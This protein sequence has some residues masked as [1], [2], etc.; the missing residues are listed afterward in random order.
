MTLLFSHKSRPDWGTA[1]LIREDDGKRTFLFWNGQQRTFA[2]AQWNLLVAVDAGVSTKSE[3]L[4]AVPPAADE[5]DLRALSLQ[6]RIL[7]DPVTKNLYEQNIRNTPNEGAFG[8]TGR[9]LMRDVLEAWV[10][11]E[12][13]FA[14][15]GLA[16]AIEFL[17]HSRR[18]EEVWGGEAFLFYRALHEEALALAYW[19]NGNPEGAKEAFLA[20][21]I[22][23][24]K[25][26]ESREN[27]RRTEVGSLLLRWMAAGDAQRGLDIANSLPIPKPKAH[28][29]DIKTGRQNK[30][31]D[32][33][34]RINETLAKQ[35]VT[36]KS[37]RTVHDQAMRYLGKEIQE[38]LSRNDYAFVDIPMHIVWMKVFLGDVMGVGDPKVVI[39]RLYKLAP[40]VRRPQVIAMCL[41][42]K[43]PLRRG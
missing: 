16:R 32:A 3:E 12:Y 34:A 5:S 6:T 36:G 27:Q 39:A 35:L 19:L 42:G 8:N 4:P 20:A 23:G 33:F 7:G 18:V 14:S 29:E 43:S 22:S 38:N 28:P 17:E 31:Y 1:Q 9:N 41:S 25:N 10:V 37:A 24:K 21:A 40:S 11:G 15:R 13:E 26:F 30:Y 2:K